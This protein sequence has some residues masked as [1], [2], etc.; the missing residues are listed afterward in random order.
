VLAGLHNNAGSAAALPPADY[1]DANIQ[2]L[3]EA[4]FV[5]QPDWNG[6]FATMATGGLQIA[7]MDAAWSW[8]EPDAPVDAGHTYTW[9]NPG[10]PA[11]S[12]DQIVGSLAA[13]GLR[14]L[15]VIDLP[16]SWA[17]G[18]GAQMVPAYYED[19]VAFAAAFA[20]R[21]G[22][23]GTFWQQNPPQPPSVT[24][25][26]PHSSTSRQGLRRCVRVSCA[27]AHIHRSSGPARQ[28]AP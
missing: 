20:A 23:G 11:H 3:F 19:C 5:P 25:S 4:S 27:A 7:R 15:A 9:S 1:Y 16:P 2:P 26:A 13:H 12:L 24:A 17:A 14:M 28:R 8:A 10:D 21:Y 6:L 18:S 22:E